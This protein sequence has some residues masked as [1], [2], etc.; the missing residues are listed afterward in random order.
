M[1]SIEIKTT[2][3]VIL[4]YELADL[5]DRAVAFLIDMAVL[6]IGLAILSMLGFAG[7]GLSGTGAIVF[8][9]FLLCIFFFYSLVMELL[10][11][12]QSVGKL[13]MKIQ[14]IKTVGGQATFSDYAARWVFRMIDIWF[15]LGGIASLLVASSVKAQRIGDIVANTAVIKLVPRM[16]LKL[17]DV[18]AI[19]S[20]ESYKVM[21]HQ[22]RQLEEVDVLLIKTT[23]ERFREFRNLAHERAVR[24]LAD[25]VK[26]R[27]GVVPAAQ[28]DIQFLQTVLNDYVVLTR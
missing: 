10:N 24:A 5:R 13:V 27:L 4:E 16:D 14:V 23:L 9:I 7:L 19:R 12:G 8:T 22:A 11:N 26:S 20:Q 28:T 3:N 17:T 18:L 15:S 25:K 6:G 2:Q 1:K 21:F